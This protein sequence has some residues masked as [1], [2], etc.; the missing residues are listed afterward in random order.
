MLQLEIYLSFCNLTGKYYSCNIIFPSN[1][2]TVILNDLKFNKKISCMFFCILLGNPKL[3]GCT[4]FHVA[5]LIAN[6][7]WR[8]SLGLF[9]FMKNRIMNRSSFFR[10]V[11]FCFMHFLSEKKEKKNAIWFL[12]LTDR[13][14]NFITNFRNNVIPD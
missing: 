11:N 7:K 14:A 9:L 6:G 13:F 2:L 10:Y 3:A 12:S 1:F 4:F 5:F 8:K